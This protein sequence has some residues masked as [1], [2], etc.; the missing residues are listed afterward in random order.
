MLYRILAD[1]VVGLH[2]LFVLFVV[3]GGFLTFRWPRLAWVHVPSFLW[4]GGIELAGWVCPLTYLEN[5]LRAQGAAAGYADSF[6]EHY[7]LPLLYPELLFTGGF[8]RT[9]FIWI[10]IFVLLLNGLIYGR[11]WWSRYHKPS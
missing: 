9:G 11:L 7:V 1:A 6:V 4:G 5:D 8:P 10:G 3:F 2:F